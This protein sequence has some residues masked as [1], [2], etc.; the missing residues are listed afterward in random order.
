MYIFDLPDELLDLCCW[1]IDHLQ[2]PLDLDGQDNSAQVNRD[3]FRRLKV[4][5]RGLEQSLIMSV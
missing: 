5:H 1:Q 3:A 4:A 2:V